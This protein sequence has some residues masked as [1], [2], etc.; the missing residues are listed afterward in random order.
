MEISRKKDSLGYDVI[1]MTKEGIT[2][3][4]FF[5]GNGDLYWDLMNL[6]DFESQDESFVISPSDGPI[7]ELFRRLFCSIATHQ[8]F[9]VDEV[10]ASFCSTPEALERIRAQKVKENES[11]SRHPYFNDLCNGSYVQWHSDNEPFE[12]GNI[13]TILLDRAGRV[14]INIKRVSREYDFL[15]VCFTQSGSRYRP[16]D[17]AFYKNYTELCEMDLTVDLPSESIEGCVR[18]RESQ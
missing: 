1:K 9:E 11:L 5:G 13:L 14:I 12:T 2:L 10:E 18:T 16:F 7:F 4:I 6:D 8:I 17:L 3:T 15:N